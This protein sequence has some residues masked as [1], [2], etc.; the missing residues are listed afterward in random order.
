MKTQFAP[1]IDHYLFSVV[2]SEEDQCYL[3]KVAEFESLMAHGDTQAEA[4]SEMKAILSEVLHDLQSNEETIPLPFGKRNFSGKL[5]LRMP[6]VLHRQLSIEAA[7][8]GVSLNQ[9]I[10]MKLAAS[11]HGLI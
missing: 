3:A 9:L 8:Q 1:D 7:S 2:W 6:E 11:T 5:N 4:L 10:N